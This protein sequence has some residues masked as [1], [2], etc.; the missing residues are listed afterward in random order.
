MLYG[1]GPLSAAPSPPCHEAV[2]PARSTRRR[3]RAGAPVGCR[4]GGRPTGQAA[5]HAQAA[6]YVPGEVVVRY[7]RGTDRREEAAV[8][9]AT[10][11][12]ARAPSRHARACC[13]IRDGES[14]ADTV[15]ELRARPEVATAAPNARAQL[16]GFIP[17]D[18]GRTGARRRLA[19]AAV[20]LPRR[21]GR[22]RARRLAAPARRRPP[23]RPRRRG[24]GARHRRRVLGPAGA[25]AGRPTSRAATSCAATTS[26]TTTG[27]RTTRTATA[28]TWPA[29]SARARTTTA[30][31]PASPTA[32]R[33]CR[34]ACS[35]HR[36][37]GESA[38]ITAGIR[39]AVRH[40]ADVINLSFE[41]DDGFRQ[42]T[43]VR[44]P[45][46]ARGAP[47]RRAARRGGGRRGRQL[48]ARRDRLPGPRADRDRGRRDDRA[49]LPRATTP[50]S[51]ARSTSWRR[52][53]GRTTPTTRRARRTLPDGRDI[54][55]MTFPWAG[56]AERAARLVELP[57]LRPAERLRRHVD[58]RAARVGHRRARDRLAASSARTRRRRP[59]QERL[60]ATAVDAGPPGLRR[61]LRLRPARRRRGHRSGAAR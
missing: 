31:S 15:R 27:S 52:A 4:R 10:G 49:R 34:S 39:Y 54:Y 38:A 23:R 53:A 28:R 42:F 30:A 48:R 18:P 25:S 6:A 7:E 29:R 37:E 12:G 3:P 13:T 47:L 57:P 60:Q 50:T 21:R 8:Q 33:S 41:F 56:V 51:A 20:E 9:R 46:R 17:R 35:T 32:P 24:R 61:G 43:R 36:G 55:Q 1:G 14:V 40:G 26:S 11:V 58:G 16:A 5:A 2:P 19:G 44:D 22:Q 59:S 45:R